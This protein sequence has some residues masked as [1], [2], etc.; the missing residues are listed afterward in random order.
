MTTTTVPA[1]ELVGR[2]H[3]RAVLRR[4][5]A[6]LE[7]GRG[8][9]ALLAG[10]AGVGKTRLAEDAMQVEEVLVLRGDTSEQP[11]P[12][13][14]PIV[15]ALR[16]FLRLDRRGLDASGPLSGYLRVLLPEL[17][18][19]PPGG[20][21]A[22]LCEALR[23]AF[24]AVSRRRPTVVF[25]DDLHWADATTLELLPGLAA[26]LADERVLILGAYR[27]DEIPRGHPLRKTRAEL[28]RAGRLHELAVRP[29]DPKWT[30]ELATRVLGSVPSP[31]LARAIHDRTQG[32]PFF[33]EE[34]C[35]ALEA[36]GRLVDGRSGLELAAGEGIPLPDTVR[37]AILTRARPVSPGA[38]RVREVAS[39]AGVRFDLALVAELAGDKAI[40][41]L[42]S[43]GVVVE[44]EPGVGAFRH[45]LVREAFYLDVTWGRRRVLHRRFAE[46]LE[47][48]G[49]RP[50][51]VAE[52]WVAASEPARARPALLAA[53]RDHHAVHAYRDA[54]EASR[55]ALELPSTDSDEQRVALLERIGR[56]AEL[57]GELGDA[58][59][60]WEQAADQR[61]RAG[62]ALGAAELDRRL[63]VV[64]ELQGAWESA[65]AAHQRAAW[66]FGRTGQDGDAAA[67]L[68]AA[69]SHLDGMGSLTPALELVEHAA[70]YASRSGRRD[71]VAR[72]LGLEG[73]VR[74]KLGD[75]DAGVRLAREGLSIALAE[76]LTGAATELYQRLAA[77]LENTADLGGAQQVYGEAY[78]FC[79]ANG[80]S[81]AAQVCLVCLAYIL[82]ETGRWDEA[83]ALERKIIASPDCPVGVVMAARSALAIFQTAR[84]R[85]RGTRRLLIAG[86]T[87]AR[88]YDRLRFEFNCLVGLAWLDELEGADASA[89][90]RY[91]EIVRRRG[92]T[93]DKHYAPMALRSAVTFF[94]AHGE[95]A[96]ARACAAALADMAA[97]TTNRETLAA[98]AHALGE[99]ALLEGEP[100]H[101]VVEFG[102]ALDL[103]RELELPHARAHTQIRAAAA[104]AEAGDRQPAVERLSDAY[105]TAR[106][107]GAH[108]LAAAA[109]GRL[110]ELGERVD[111]RLG[112][113][114]AGDL[115]RAGLTRRELEVMRF[116]AVGRTNREIAEELFLS[117]R[118][119]DMHVRSI[120]MKL[121]CGSRTEATRRAWELGL[122][123]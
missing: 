75:L 82:W 115:A 10:E 35:A 31:P 72:S 102:R 89:S 79:V 34:L 43:L 37:D 27:S 14:G 74:A 5:L 68:L 15:A 23:R 9:I 67:E 119:V 87:Y 46:L 62:N 101:A 110:E 22:T 49:A 84:G 103:L 40:D 3:E 99:V 8:G 76:S 26:G 111:Q 83:E 53:A 93:E 20:D 13:Y 90:T 29:L 116:V 108:P 85:S 12:P 66:G 107:L 11:P 32:V 106:K 50:A 1:E 113:R 2:D 58:V 7:A 18:D 118:T 69:V 86:L 47:E 55:R 41:E 123:D 24:E 120:L 4:A 6:E 33:V 104:L 60:A 21:R 121:S 73:S 30:A 122:V 112:R 94:A 78:E 51:L 92:E 17:G 59:L 56:Y 57:C 61:R 52:H 91:H 45:V 88:Q 100:G 38:R 36:A 109:A 44:V 80:S 64:Y 95:P 28:R 97:A 42:V 96:A 117:K 70:A 19:A 77:V 98:L 65:L 81:G 25:L 39:V 16:D 54:L 48:R 71:L 105:R 63:A 114:A